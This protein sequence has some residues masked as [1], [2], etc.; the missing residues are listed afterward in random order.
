M[1]GEMSNEFFHAILYSDLT[2]VQ[3]MLREGT[4]S[5]KERDD[6]GRTALLLAIGHI[7]TVPYSTVVP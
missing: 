3:R 2:T 1:Y 6:C 7:S 5:T 4:A